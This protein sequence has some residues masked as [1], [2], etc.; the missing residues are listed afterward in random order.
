MLIQV[1]R[2]SPGP[3]LFWNLDNPQ[4]TELLLDDV[5]LPRPVIPRLQLD[6]PKERILKHLTRSYVRYPLK[7]YYHIIAVFLLT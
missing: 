7:K 3:G 5:D 6:T 1:H 4:L 2:H